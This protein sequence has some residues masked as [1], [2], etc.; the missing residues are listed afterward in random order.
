[1]G[2]LMGTDFN[3]DGIHGIGPKTA[4]KIVK[5]DYSSFKAL[6][7][8][9]DIEWDGENDPETIIEFFKNPPVEDPE[10]EFVQPDT[11]KIRQIMIEEHEFSENRINPA[12][13]KLVT[14]ME[15]RQSGLDSFM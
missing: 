13:E 5:K 1:M 7:D 12:I 15:S 14:A 3:P 2:V 6:L 9:E 10:F 11:D 4:L 8:E